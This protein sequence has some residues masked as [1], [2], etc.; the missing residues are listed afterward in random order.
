[1]SEAF[2]KRLHDVLRGIARDLILEAHKGQLLAVELTLGKYV[3]HLVTILSRTEPAEEPRLTDELIRAVWRSQVIPIADL[4][5]VMKPE[6]PEEEQPLPPPRHPRSRRGVPSQNPD[7][8]ANGLGP[9][10]QRKL[11]MLKAALR[12]HDCNLTQTGRALGANVKT[13]RHWMQRHRLTRQAIAKLPAVNPKAIVT[14]DVVEFQAFKE[15]W[16]ENEHNTHAT[17]RALELNIK[18]THLRLIRFGLKKRLGG[19]FDEKAKYHLERAMEIAQGEVATAA[20]YLGVTSRA[21]YYLL[22]RG[23]YYQ[24]GKKRGEGHMVDWKERA[25]KRRESGGSFQHLSESWEGFGEYLKDQEK[26]E[27][28]P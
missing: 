9:I 16:E 12:V 15:A 14:W 4:T 26:S 20:R 7:F 1:M 17:A 10:E 6:E 13:V 21:L 11:E 19:D 2:E 27:D 5:G 22:M 25:E 3:E 18:T 23:G 28:S 24:P 8:N